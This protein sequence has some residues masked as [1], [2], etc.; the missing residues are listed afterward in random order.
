MYSTPVTCAKPHV[1]LYNKIALKCISTLSCFGTSPLVPKRYPFHSSVR[2]LPGGKVF[3]GVGGCFS[4]SQISLS[5]EDFGT[6]AVNLQ[7]TELNILHTCRSYL[8]LTRGVETNLNS[9]SP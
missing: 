9:T 2:S 7:A 6:H 5:L 1:D 3:W 4:Q 8:T